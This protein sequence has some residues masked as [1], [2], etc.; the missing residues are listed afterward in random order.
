[1]L[2]RNTIRTLRNLQR[3]TTRPPT[4]ADIDNQTHDRLDL[5]AS[6]QYCQAITRREAK[7]FYWGFIALPK[8]QRVAIYALYSFARQVDDAVDLRG[9]R[10][11]ESGLAID[12]GGDPLALHRERLARC[13]AGDAT[14]PVTQVLAQVVRRYQIPQVELEALIRG[15]EMDLNTTRYETWED[16]RGYCQLVASSIGRMCVRVFGYNDPVALERADDLGVAM[17]LANTLRDVG[18]DLGRGRVYLPQVDLRRFGITETALAAGQPGDGWAP[19]MHEQIDRARQT[20]ERGLEVADYIPRR[21]A[22]CVRTMAGIYQAILERLED[23][24]TIPLQR[25]LSLDSRTKLGVTLKS[26]AQVMS[27]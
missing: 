2:G 22:V 23:D 10:T 11:G 1:M 8:T 20:F 9:D 13:F 6:E 7:N 5:A 16:L 15:V 24:P 19:M 14:D 27:P 21:A 25:R 17:Q 26:W 3:D 18:E 12:P 4:P